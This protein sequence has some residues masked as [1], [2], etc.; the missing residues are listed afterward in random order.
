MSENDFTHRK[1]VVYKFIGDFE[2]ELI[3]RDLYFEEVRAL[4]ARNQYLF[5]EDQWAW[6]MRR[7]H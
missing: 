4:I 1:F 7:K 3:A 2:I 6:D 5:F